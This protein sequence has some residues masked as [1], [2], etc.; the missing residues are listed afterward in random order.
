M[1]RCYESTAASTSAVM[2]NT[3]ASSF[4]AGTTPSF[5]GLGP[6]LYGLVDDE[7]RRLASDLTMRAGEYSTRRE[8][9]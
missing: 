5:P 6:A 9:W 4:F 1:Q 2:S 8:S 7:L 3:Y